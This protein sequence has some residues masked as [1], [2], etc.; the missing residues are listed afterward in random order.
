MAIMASRL[1]FLIFNHAP[2]LAFPWFPLFGTVFFTCRHTLPFRPRRPL[3]FFYNSYTVP[4]NSPFPVFKMRAGFVALAL[5]AASVAYA[6]PQAPDFVP[7]DP[8]AALLQLEQLG[9]ATYEAV[10]SDLA[11]AAEVA[12]RSG[13][14]TGSCTLTK[15][16]IRREWYVPP[17]PR[18]PHTPTNTSPGAR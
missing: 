9:N 12:K 11:E 2:V 14:L 6:L 15:L 4:V 10:E 7:S 17:F 16:K 13:I 8:E 18:P 3:A 1:G 5:Q